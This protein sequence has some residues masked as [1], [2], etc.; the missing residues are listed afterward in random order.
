MHRLFYPLHVAIFILLCGEAKAQDSAP[1]SEDSISA[2][3]S[4]WHALPEASI[5]TVGLGAGARGLDE[6]PGALHV[7]SPAELERYAFTDPLRVLR[8]VSGVNIQEE[9]GY[10]L[11][12]NIGLRGSGSERSARIT[13]MEDGVLM[14][15]APYTAP[16]AYYF[17]SIA[18]MSAVEVLKGSSQIAFG[19]Q[20]AGGAINLVTTAIDD[21]PSNV[22]LRSEIS[23]YGGHLRHIRLV[24]QWTGK[25]GKWGTLV[26]GMQLGSDG[27]KHLPG[28]QPTGFSKT[29]GIAK[30]RWTAA[31]ERRVAQSFQFKVG[32]VEEDSHETYAGLT[33]A[34]FEADPLA[35]YAASARDRMMADQ[36]QAVLR[37]EVT[38]SERWKFETDVYRTRFHRNWYKLDGYRDAS[39]ER[40]SLLSLYTSNQVEVLKSNTPEEEALLVKANNRWYGTRGVQHRGTFKWGAGSEQQVV[41]GARF[42]SDWVD[43]FQWRDAYRLSDDQ[44]RLVEA[45]TPGSAGNRIDGARA[46]AG[47]VRATLR[48]ERWTLTPGIRTERMEFFRQSYASHDW[49]RESSPEERNNAVHVWLPG[50]GLTYE[51]HNADHLFLGVHR[52][53]IP[54]GSAPNTLPETSLNAELGYRWSRE[55]SA[56]QLVAFHN[57]YA[58]LLGSD[59]TATGGLGTGDLF[60][61]GSAQTSGVECEWAGE[62]APNAARIALPLRL[63]YTY[64]RAM[65]TS[66]FESDFGPW[67]VV[68]EGD[69]LPY[70]SPHQGNAQL[71]IIRG[72]YALE[73]NA[74]YASSMRVA[75]GQA[76][77]NEANATDAVTVLDALYRFGINEQ[78]TAYVGVN[79]AFNS[80]VV[81]AMRPAGLRPNMPRLFRAGLSITL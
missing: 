17:P 12:P 62:L 72:D 32:L 59:L 37:H 80:T 64:T 10:G 15:P 34:D 36:S 4:Q 13:L 49:E 21:A 22:L 57:T 81:V 14:A 39:S 44:M 18:R 78:C 20:T 67:S 48:H 45:G 75:A 3:L 73:L 41:Y 9:D 65:F 40:T 7:I 76:K 8:A 79:N 61:G 52:G 42:H 50:V 19:P 58:D 24:H 66:A 28:G 6:V 29:D 60:N 43:R 5:E 31:P 25:K 35:R 26:E 77:P 74:R 71:S 11:R 33:E 63:T 23:G 47:F 16:A 30:V 70:L 56:G 1:L 2:M 55:H 69:F 53:F 68:E 27:F 38:V 51:L 46:F 54:P